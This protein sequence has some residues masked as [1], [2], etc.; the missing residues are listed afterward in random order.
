VP[1]VLAGVVV[2]VLAG[3]VVVVLAGVVVEVLAGVEVPEVTFV[4]AGVED[5]RAEADDVVL[6][7]DVELLRDVVVPALVR[8]LEVVA[9]PLGL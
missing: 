8:A 4:V 7:L 9:A 2:V 1:D 5:V 3:V 6:V